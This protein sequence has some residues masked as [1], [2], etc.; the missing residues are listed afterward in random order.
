MKEEFYGG[1]NMG[2]GDRLV[3]QMSIDTA[4]EMFADWKDTPQIN[5]KK[6]EG[7]DFFRIE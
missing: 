3:T 2:K 4:N 6:G 5:Y 7:G 1:I